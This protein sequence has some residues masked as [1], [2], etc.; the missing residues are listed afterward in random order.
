MC[1][2]IYVDTDTMTEED[3]FPVTKKI[4]EK[5]KKSLTPVQVP[6]HQIVLSY[7]I[8]ED[9]ELDLKY[10][11]TEMRRKPDNSPH[12]KK[13]NFARMFSYWGRMVFRHEFKLQCYLSTGPDQKFKIEIK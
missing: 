7:N 8:S 12:K 11:K 10:Y 4:V 9:Y 13:N 3:Y 2:L 5:Y 6:K 1:A